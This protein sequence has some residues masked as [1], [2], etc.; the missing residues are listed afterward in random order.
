MKIKN[1]IIILAVFILTS[2]SSTYYSGQFDI[3]VGN[4]DYTSKEDAVNK[5]KQVALKNSLTIDYSQT[6]EDTLSFF[7]PP[8]HYIQFFIDNKI[9]HDSIA[10]KLI[11]DGRLASQRATD[12]IYYRLISQIDSL[13]KGRI[14]YN[15]LEKK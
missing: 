8:Y 7:G 13:Y 12:N 3:Y 14:K 15:Q 9:K 6:N 2:C 10:I 4:N 1:I 5:I 11:Y